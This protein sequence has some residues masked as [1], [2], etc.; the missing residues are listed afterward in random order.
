[1]PFLNISKWVKTWITTEIQNYLSGQSEM[2]DYLKWT[3]IEKDDYQVTVSNIKHLF[4]DFDDNDVARTINPWSFLSWIA[5][6]NISTY[7]WEPKTNSKHLRSHELI[8]WVFCSWYMNVAVDPVSKELYSI[9]S[10]SY[11]YDRAKKKEYFVN[12]NSVEVDWDIKVILTVDTVQNKIFKKRVFI[13]DNEYDLTVWKL[14]KKWEIEWVTATETEFNISKERLVIDRFIQYPIA[15]KIARI[16][17]SIEKKMS[18]IEKNFQDY[19]EQ[20]KIFRNLE[21][22]DNCY[23]TLD[24][25]VRVVDFDKLWKIISTNDLNWW[26]WGIDIVKNTNDMLIDSI[27]YL[28][29]QIRSI[30]AISS[31]PL[32]NFWIKQE[33]WQD[34]WTSLVKSSWLFY[35]KIENLRE[36]FSDIINQYFEENEIPEDN[37]KLVFNEIISVDSKELIDNNIKLTTAWLQSKIRAIMKIHDVSKAEAEIILSEII[38]D[39]EEELKFNLKNNENTKSKEKWDTFSKNKNH[40]RQKKKRWYDREAD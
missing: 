21:I 23:R 20:F 5:F 22:P 10:D 38:K 19:T 25:W 35:K 40:W 7:F 9:S 34:S 4:P 37:R 24:T 13:L 12:L 14:V 17:I 16:Q 3:Y 15:K 2:I 32:F 36:N 18:E 39:K 29:N 1:M 11:Y 6:D 26:L 33:W 27:K 31:V 30:S 8:E 28:N